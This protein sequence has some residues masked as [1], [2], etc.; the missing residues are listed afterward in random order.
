[1]VGSG[2]WPDTESELHPHL[3]NIAG[4][5]ARLAPDFLQGFAWV[6]AARGGL[7]AFVEAG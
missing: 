5:R 7:F 2:L 1:M 4:F 6:L 3:L